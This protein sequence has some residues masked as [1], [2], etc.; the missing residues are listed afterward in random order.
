M[1]TAAGTSNRDLYRNI[2]RLVCSY[3]SSILFHC[4]I[5]W[6]RFSDTFWHIRILRHLC[7]TNVKGT[8]ASLPSP[9][10]FSP[11]LKL[12]CI[13]KITSVS[14]RERR[15]K[16]AWRIKDVKKEWGEQKIRFILVDK[17]SRRLTIADVFFISTVSFRRKDFQEGTD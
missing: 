5:C 17:H 9:F 2:F 11:L 1:Y 4:K 6:G 10:N 15:K 12:S 7:S 14:A 3:V 8:H 13:V 16:L